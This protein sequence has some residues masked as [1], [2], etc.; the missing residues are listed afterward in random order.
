MPKVLLVDDHAL[1]RQGLRKAF[2]R[3][4]DF[5][6]VGDAS[7]L[8]DCLAL[9]DDLIPDV[10][11]IDINLADGS[12]GLDA[13]SRLR[14]QYPTMGIVVLTMYDDDKHMFSA[15]AAGASAFVPKSVSTDQIIA[16]ARQAVSAPTSFSAADLGNAMRRRMAPAAMQLNPRETQLLELLS[17]GL[18]VSAI[19]RRM[20]ISDSTVKSHMS[21]L[22]GKLGANNRSQALM[23]AVRL[24]IIT[25]KV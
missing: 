10:A 14:Q 6:V 17:D 20:F 4:T 1:I 16:A 12:S 5:E 18:P 3:D 7:T 11:V 25:T 19:A 21:K 8:A 23:A 9:A 24:G 2:E 13:V 22:Y 15:M